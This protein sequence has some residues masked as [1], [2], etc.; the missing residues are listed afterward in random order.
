MQGMIKRP[1]VNALI[2]RF[3]DKLEGILA[4]GVL[5]AVGSWI[6]LDYMIGVARKEVTGYP[7]CLARISPEGETPVVWGCPRCGREGLV[8]RGRDLLNC[9]AW[10]SAEET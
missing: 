1:S 6:A 3:R 4:L 9:R 8:K 2:A 10:E 5:A 7:H